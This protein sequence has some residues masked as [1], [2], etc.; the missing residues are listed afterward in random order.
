LIIELLVA[1]AVPGPVYYF[2][3]GAYLARRSINL[4]EVASH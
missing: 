3:R 4:T 2:I 1:L